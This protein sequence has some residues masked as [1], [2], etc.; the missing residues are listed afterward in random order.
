MSYGGTSDNQ[1]RGSV[2]R[3]EEAR[4][5]ARLIREQHKK[6]EKRSVR[7]VRGI[8]A[9]SSIAVLGIV[10]IVILTSIPR[11]GP[12]PSNMLSDG[13]VIGENYVAT[14][15]PALRAGQLP[16]PTK[17][18]TGSD[19]ISIQIYVD[20]FCTTCKAFEEAN[21]EQISKWVKSGAATLEVHPLAI[22]DRVSQGSRYSSR[23]ANAAGCVA[24]F[25]PDTFYA[26]HQL[27]F[28]KQPDENTSG[29]SDTELQDI[30]VQSHANNVSIIKKCIADQTFRTWVSEAKDRALTGPIPNSNV[31]TVSTTPTVIVNGVKYPGAANDAVAFSAFVVQAA[32]TSFNENVTAT[33]TPTP[34]PTP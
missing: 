9:L 18:E 27:M 23:A 11:V 20:Y 13:I 3:R 7:M 16:I 19:V 30:V 22:L 24:N 33:P 5:K 2:S 10:A 28:A 32:G 25:S 26:F 34:E 1:R 15:T 8:I 12:G 17:R 31:E 4:E 29:L 21:G 6:Q 14:P